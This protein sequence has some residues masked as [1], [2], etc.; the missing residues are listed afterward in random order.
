MGR[1]LS[2]LILP[3][4]HIPS[5]RNSGSGQGN[6]GQKAMFVQKRHIHTTQ[7]HSQGSVA[8]NIWGLGAQHP[9]TEDEEKGK[10]EA[11]LLWRWLGHPHV[12]ISPL[13]GPVGLP[14][15]QPHTYK[16]L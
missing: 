7:T 6:R 3:P 16:P 1:V 10:E 5:W 13:T 2:T 8:G 15:S 11:L 12:P 9:M 4:R 14:D